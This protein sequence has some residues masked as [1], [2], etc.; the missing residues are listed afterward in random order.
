MPSSRHVRMT[1]TAI[2]PRLAI[3]N[4]AEQERS[5]TDS[6]Q[7]DAV[8]YGDARRRPHIAG[9]AG[10]TRWRVE[11]FAE[12]DS[13]NRYA[14]RRGARD[15]GAGGPGRRRRPPDRGAGPARPHVGGPARL[16]AARVGAPATGARRVRRSHAWWSW[17]PRWRSPTPW[18]R[19]RASRRPEVAQRPGGATTA[20]SPG[21]S[22]RRE[23]RRASVVGAGCNVN[24]E[25]VPAEL[26]ATAT[27]CNLEAGHA[28]RPRRAARRVPRRRSVRCLD[29]TSTRPAARVP[30]RLVTLGRRVRVERARRCARPARRSRSTDAGRARRTRRRRHRAQVVVGDVVHLRSGLIPAH[31]SRSRATRAR[32]ASAS[33]AV[34]GPGA[35]GSDRA[36]DGRDGLHLAHGRGEERFVG[37][38]ERADRQRPLLGADA[39]LRAQLEHERARHAEQAAGRRGRRATP[40]RRGRRTRSTRSPRTAR[41]ACWRTSPR[42]RPVPARTRARARSPRTR[43]S[44]ARRSRPARCGPTARRPRSLVGAHGLERAR[45][46]DRPSAGA[47]PRSEPSGDTPPVTVIAQARLAQAV[48]ARAPRRRPRGARPR[49]GT[50]S[51]SPRPTAPA[52]RGAGATRTGRRRRRAGLEHAVADEQP[53]VERAR[54]ARRRRRRARRRSRRIGA[55]ARPRSSG[56]ADRALVGSAGATA[57]SS[58]AALSSVSSHSAAGTESATMPRADAELGA[59]RANT[60]NVRMAT[61]RSPV[62]RARCRSSRTRR[63]TRRAAPARASSMTWSTR[64]LGA[65][66]D[67]R[68]RERGADSAPSRRRAGRAR[69]RCSRGGAGPDAPRP[70]TARHV[71]RPGFAHPTEVVAGEV[72]DHHVLGVVLRAGAQRCRV[73]GGALDRSGL[74]RGARSRA[75]TAR[76]TRVTTRHRPVPGA[77]PGAARCRAPGACRTSL[78]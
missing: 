43:W 16:V 2:S 66:G 72:D 73:A 46:H 59:V 29:A 8:S 48:R 56:H 14:P 24:W 55:V 57:A 30:R 65:P 11:R 12:L 21:S 7:W 70:R 13:T 69:A 26:A 77:A 27:A 44:S 41:R 45:R 34:T 23:R 31:G 22:P 36:V 74:H 4:F 19:W 20:S 10:G 6:R 62:A 54:R 9:D 38:R 37:R 15:G 35:D 64:G 53:V 71:D 25:R 28:G 17:R 68:G 40:R 42:P 3:K 51:P 76:A 61:A 49:S 78:P 67:R 75:G 52:D 47:S 5:S 63:S 18:T 39:V 1:R 33:A 50:A 60:V 58:R 32:N